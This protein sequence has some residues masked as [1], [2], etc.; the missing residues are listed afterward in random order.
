MGRAVTAYAST[1]TVPVHRTRSEL[2]TVLTRFGADQFGYG[3]DDSRWM[4]AFRVHGRSVRMTLPR[5]TASEAAIAKT[6]T[7]N[8]RSPAQITAQIEQEERRRWRALLLVVKAKLTAV[9]DGISTVE[10]EFMSDMLLPDGR[11]MGEWIEPQLAVAYQ[12]GSMPAL[13]PGVSS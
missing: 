7:G 11:T 12:S 3:H 9:S 13:M 1:T 2:E 8:R 4:V 10:R 5:P 6:P